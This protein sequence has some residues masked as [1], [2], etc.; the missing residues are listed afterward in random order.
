MI[1][2]SALL[3]SRSAAVPRAARTASTTGATPVQP[4]RPPGPGERGGITANSA[5]PPRQA[6]PVPGGQAQG[7]PA[8]AT[9]RPATAGAWWQTGRE[10]LRGQPGQHRRQGGDGSG[11]R[12]VGESTETACRRVEHDLG[13]CLGDQRDGHPQGARGVGAEADPQRADAGGPEVEGQLRLGGG[14]PGGGEDGPR[15]QAQHQVRRVTGEPGGVEVDQHRGP[16]GDAGAQIDPV[17]EP[18]GSRGVGATV[19]QE[20]RDGVQQGGHRDGQVTGAVFQPGPRVGEQPG[21]PGDPWRRSRPV[22]ETGRGE[23]GVQDL[24]RAG[25]SGWSSRAQGG[26]R[27]GRGGGGDRVGGQG[28]N[29]SRVVGLGGHTGTCAGPRIPQRRGDSRSGA[30]PA[31]RVAVRR[32]PRRRTGDSRVTAGGEPEG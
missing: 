3:T 28:V 19:G 1:R 23:E 27:G 5:T 10:V 24:R 4:G 22:Q 16:A 2:P 7:R 18:Q 11:R 6:R 17:G 29:A 31:G 26:Q 32:G 25:V 9:T 13:A 12:G 21:G 20:P 30:P 15:R 8:Q 14:G